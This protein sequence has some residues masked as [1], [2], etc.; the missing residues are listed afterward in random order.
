MM[1]TAVLEVRSL[2]E[3]LQDVSELVN[4]GEQETE[5]HIS[6]ATV[7]LLWQ[8][9]TAQR[10]TLLK[11]LCGAG[12]LSLTEVAKQVGQD[13]VH[14]AE[15]IQALTQVGLLTQTADGRVEFPYEAIKVQFL[16]HA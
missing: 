9:F 11:A 13:S 10:W 7:E 12:A 4:R 8:L 16:L 15:D 6:F 2:T 5:T 3:V 1:N 14:V